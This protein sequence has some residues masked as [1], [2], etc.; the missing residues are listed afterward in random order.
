MKATKH[1]SVHSQKIHGLIYFYKTFDV[2]QMRY[3]LTARRFGVES[4]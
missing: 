4:L 1:Q 2:D 3:S